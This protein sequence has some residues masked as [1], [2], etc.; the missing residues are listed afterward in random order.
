MGKGSLRT[1]KSE[2]FQEEPSSEA[3]ERIISDFLDG[4][5]TLF[6]RWDMI[7][8]SWRLVDELVH[9]KDDCPI[10][11]PYFPGTS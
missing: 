5:K 10:L 11:H 8:E 6:T 4:D 7:E 9:C 1:A 2:F 3:Y